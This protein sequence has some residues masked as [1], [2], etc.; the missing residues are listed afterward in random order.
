MR[1][2][3]F[4]KQETEALGNIRSARPEYLSGET[5]LNFEYKFSTG[6]TLKATQNQEDVAAVVIERNGKTILDFKDLSAEPV[7][8]L[9]ASKAI[10]ETK[11]ATLPNAPRSD[12][13]LALDDEGKSN[14]ISIGDMRESKDVLSLLHELGHTYQQYL[15]RM[16]REVESDVIRVGKMTEGQKMDVSVISSVEERDAWAWALKTARRIRDELG[17]DLLEVFKNQEDLIKEVHGCLLT[18]RNH[19]TL[20]YISDINPTDMES[21]KNGLLGIEGLSSLF[22]KNRLRRLGPTGESA[23]DAVDQENGL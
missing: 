3:F 11:D 13:Y 6:E 4:T 23:S 19:Y 20:L 7:R 18:H 21:L 10:E 5:P 14:F 1:E 12:W 16:K 17:I 15:F 22:D 9:S 2:E 8:F